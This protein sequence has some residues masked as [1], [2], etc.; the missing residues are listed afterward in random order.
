MS[1]AL[2]QQT[3]AIVGLGLMGGSLALAL[4]GRVARIVGI[5]P[6]EATLAFALER[7]II[8]EG[9]T[10]VQE[11]VRAASAVILAAQFPSIS[12]IDFETVGIFGETKRKRCCSAA[13]RFIVVQRIVSQS[14]V[15]Q[16]LQSIQ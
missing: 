3:I 10:G 15:A 16:S 13:P 12:E 1:A 9:T 8:D 7:G 2:S 6:D 14:V 5:D 4:R 11:G